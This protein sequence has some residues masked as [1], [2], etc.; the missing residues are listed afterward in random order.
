MIKLKVNK[1]RVGPILGRHPWVFS[2]AL[3]LIPE[4]LKNGEPIRLVD[5]TGRFLAMG[6]FNSYSQMAVRVWG[7]DENETVDKSFFIKRIEQALS[8]RKKYLDQ[9]KNNSYRIVNSE[10]D[11]LPGLVIDKYHNYLSIQFH[12]SGIQRWQP[13]IISACEEILQPSGM[14]IRLADKKSITSGVVPDLVEIKENGFKFLVDM[15]AGQKT[16]FFL[17]QRDKRLALQKYVQGQNVLNCFSYTG[18]F[19]VYALAAGAKKVVNV[20][21]SEAALEIA[22]KNIEL[23]GL[24]IKKCEFIC[25]DVKKYLTADLKNKFSVIIL[26]PPAFIKDRHR[27]KEG[28]IGYKKIN[29]AAMRVLPPDGI[30]VS[31]SCSQHLNLRDFRFAISE[32]ASHAGK[33]VQILETYLHGIDHPEVISFL[34]GEYL[35]CF[36]LLVK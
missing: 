26:D 24:N 9:K 17:D 4:G 28:L 35:K 32:A 34:E 8:L 31:C 19:S 15:T 30:L 27:I 2:R 20:D 1:D 6:Y 14:V 23:N 33:S 10:N 29:E 5:P 16:G 7:Y 25:Q 21:T 18:G 36:Y 12:N 22:K 3:T 11:F 13:E